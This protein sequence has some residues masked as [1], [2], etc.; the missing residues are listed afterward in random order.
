MSNQ[1][2][3]LSKSIVAEALPTDREYVL[4]DNRLAGFGLRVRPSG[5][6]SF[7]YVYRSPGGRRGT[8]RRVTLKGTH[9]DVAFE[10]AKKEAAKFHGG[11]D[12][13]A[14]RAAAADT[15]AK[16]RKVL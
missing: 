12:P 3:R 4:W 10:A 5:A 2:V 11:G 15:A 6:K 9:A 16:A 13:V 14:E 8:V 1:K 7:V